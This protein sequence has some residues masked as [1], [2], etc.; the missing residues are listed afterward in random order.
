MAVPCP[1]DTPN[2]LHK[3]ATHGTARLN[4]KLIVGLWQTRGADTKAAGPIASDLPGH[5]SVSS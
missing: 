3:P 5:L 1:D 4:V 2:D